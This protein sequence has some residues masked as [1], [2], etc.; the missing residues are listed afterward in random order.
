MKN[1][2]ARFGLLIGFIVLALTIPVTVYVANQ[3]DKQ[4]YISRAGLENLAQIYLWPA[5]GEIPRCLENVDITTCPKT[6]VEVILD[7]M[8]KTAGGVD[9][10]IKY[11][12]RFIGIVKNAIVPGLAD[13]NY[14]QLFKPFNYY[15]DGL[16]DSQNGLIK[17]K[18]VGSYAGS[19]GVVATFFITGLSSGVSRLDFLT[20]ANGTVVLDE[21]G[22][23]NILGTVSGAEI[24]VR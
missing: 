23:N 8:E 13:E 3:K 16:V 15:R 5:A 10:V 12:P 17:L 7:T 6:K 4:K 1:N 18:A 19:K 14:N 21:T 9:L 22:N 20:E 2:I 24:T 11:D